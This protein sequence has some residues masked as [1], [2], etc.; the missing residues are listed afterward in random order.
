MP[1]P[2][3]PEKIV[4][5]V[6]ICLS[7]F[8]FWYRFRHVVRIVSAAKPDP[9]FSLGHLFPR[10]RSF[11]WEVLL[12]GKVIRERPA[13]GV[14]H[15]F[16]FWG[17]CAFALIT[18][19]HIATGFGLPFL[20]RTMGFG[21][22]YFG[23]VALFAVAVAISIVY[24]AVRRFILRPVWLG[25]VSTE[26]G[27]IAGLIFLLMITYLAGFSVSEAGAD[28]RVAWWAHTLALLVFLPLVPH[29]KHLHL[30]LSPAAVFLK[31][32]LFSDIPKL[33]GDEDFGRVSG[34]DVTR[35]EALQSFSCVECGRCT[36]HCPAYNTG[37]VLNPKEVILGL[38]AYL[39]TEGPLSETPLL[40]AHIS[41]EA[42]FQCTT[43]GACEFQCPVGIQ[44]LPMIVGLRRGAVNTGAWDDSYG[45]KLF[46]TMERNGNSLGLP[47]NERWKFIEKNALPIYDG[48]QEYCLWLGCMGAYD[49][50]GRET[51][52]ALVRV[53]NHLEITFGV[54]KKEKCN[55]DPAR[56]LGNDLLFSTLAEENLETI[57]QSGPQSKAVKLLS[58]CPHC[59]RTMSVDW[60]ETC[61]TVEI[62]HHSELLDRYKTRLPVNSGNR[63]DKV[64]Y[65]DPCYLGR[66]RGVYDE[67][68]N[69]IAQSADVVEAP[70]HR[71]RS[72]CCGAGGG[73]M[74]LGEEKGK[75]IN[76]AR[77]E[78]LITTG[79]KTV[80][81]A[82]PFCASMFRDALKTVSDTPPALLDIVQIVA[83]GLSDPP[84]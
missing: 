8:G 67:P 82:C 43:C 31:R 59:V 69:V 9:G 40:G 78:E 84:P 20:S 16:V 29:T 2:G 21:R 6:L 11:A 36:E 42:A 22:V 34:K 28:W 51:I 15:A 76:V 75:R 45:T 53:L 62:E 30:V 46:L 83:Q 4:L 48:T 35:I 19:N 41:E 71:E 63:R 70:R 25:K 14:T 74:F 38:R 47:S 61:R 10:I 7:A 26:S 66:Y 54:L 3:L 24:L 18:V 65:H 27:I 72:F 64:V 57:S 80:A 79:A 49:P 17:F 13:A 56:R 73:Q 32:P 37:K 81:V 50:A 39:N 23:F 1:A 58:I 44:H 5:A 12:Q 68:R 77:A 60:R 52:L 55:G 33:A